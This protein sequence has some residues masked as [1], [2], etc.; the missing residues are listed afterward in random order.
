M[1]YKTAY[2]IGLEVLDKLKPYTDKSE[3]AG[4][5]RRKNDEVHDIDLV[6]QPKIEFMILDNIKR[7]LK[8][9]G[10]LDMEGNQIIRVKG[11]NNEVIDCY[12]ATKK[13]FEVLVLI[14]TGSANHNIKLAKKALSLGLKL[15]FS[16]GL[17][18]S[19]TGKVIANDEKS[20]FE[21]LKID[22]VE[23]EDRD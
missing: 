6:I 12:I 20:I 7:V 5:L 13:N 11:K 18:D 16:K 23:P 8:S 9:Y 17:I 10:S 3:I 14:R 19:K 22:Y 1:N 21:A 4:S 2:I 15:D